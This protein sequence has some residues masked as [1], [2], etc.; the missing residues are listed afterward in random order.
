MSRRREFS[1]LQL[2]HTT[3]KA[4]SR[5]DAEQLSAA[6]SY[7]EVLSSELARLGRCRDVYQLDEVCLQWLRMDERFLSLAETRRRMDQVKLGGTRESITMLPIINCESTRCVIW[8]AKSTKAADDARRQLAAGTLLAP[9]VEAAEGLSRASKGSV[10]VLSA[11]TDSP[12]PPAR[13]PLR[14]PGHLW[15]DVRDSSHSRRPCRDH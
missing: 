6:E 11:S 5:S 8:V 4:G 2:L 14:S 13:Q 1:R 7:T 9:T 12:V 3:A 10:R 15:T